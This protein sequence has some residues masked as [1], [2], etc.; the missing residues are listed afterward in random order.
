MGDVMGD[1]G[2]E[3]TCCKAETGGKVKSKM[4][5]EQLENLRVMGHDHGAHLPRAQGDEQVLPEGWDLG[6]EARFPP[7][8]RAEIISSAFPV[9]SSHNQDKTGQWVQPGVRGSTSRCCGQH[10]VK[11]PRNQRGSANAQPLGKRITAAE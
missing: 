2:S 7:A 6:L 4:P 5:E 1:V 8:D 11:A 3:A 10:F 9:C